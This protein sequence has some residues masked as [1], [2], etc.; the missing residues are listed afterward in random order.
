M[1]WW[2][3]RCIVN[4][5]CILSDYRLRQ[6]LYYVISWRCAC[7][8]RFAAH[9]LHHSFHIHI[10]RSWQRCVNCL[11]SLCAS[12]LVHCMDADVDVIVSLCSTESKHSYIGTLVTFIV[13]SAILYFVYSKFLSGTAHGQ[14]APP[15]YSAHPPPPGFRP[16]YVPPPSGTNRVFYILCFAFDLI[17]RWVICTRVFIVYLWHAEISMLFVS[18]LFYKYL[19]LCGCFVR[20]E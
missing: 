1:C 6:L 18:Y 12:F 16:E 15:P 20:N 13:I 5:G 8:S 9:L 19:S 3:I 2:L 7:S 10:V 17:L 14:D 11:S 4:M